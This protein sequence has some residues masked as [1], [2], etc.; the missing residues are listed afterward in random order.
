MGLKLFEAVRGSVTDMNA[1][2]RELAALAKMYKFTHGKT[3]LYDSLLILS[4]ELAGRA[5]FLDKSQADDLTETL[6]ASEK[7]TGEMLTTL[8]KHADKLTPKSA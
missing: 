5:E 3:E 7:H 1:A 2:S 6:R 4:D 8:L